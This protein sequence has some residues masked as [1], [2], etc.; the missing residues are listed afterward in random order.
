[1]AVG[2]LGG[3][4]SGTVGQFFNLT[5]STTTAATTLNFSGVSG[6]ASN[7]FIPNNQFVTIQSNPS[8]PAPL[9]PREFNRY[10][11]ASD[12]LEEFIEHMGKCGVKQSEFLNLPIEVFINWLILRAAQRDGDPVPE[13]V[14]APEDHPKAQQA[15]RV[16]HCRTCGRFL[17]RQK[18]V[19]GIMWCD[20]RHLLIFMQRQD[21]KRL[22]PPRMG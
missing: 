5:T 3:M 10:I 18:V 16:A 15:K 4:V 21:I 13:G 9:D 12:L 11:N 1:M 19:D 17:T 14:V 22:S 7:T 6:T 20:E 2:I 8:I